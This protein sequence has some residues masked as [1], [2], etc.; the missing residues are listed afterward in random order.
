MPKSFDADAEVLHDAMQGVGTDEKAIIGVLSQRTRAEMHDVDI[1]YRSKYGRMLVDKIKSEFSG[2]LERI[3]TNVVQPPALTDAIYLHDSMA[4]AGTDETV[5][6]EILATRTGEEMEKIKLAYVET[7]RNGLEQAVK[8]DTSGSIEDLLVALVNGPR[9]REGHQVDHNRAKEDARRLESQPTENNFIFIL[10][11]SSHEHILAVGEEL[12]KEFG[13]SLIDFI[14]K[15]CSG[16]FEDLLVIL[17]TP[18]AEFFA[19]RL[20]KAMKGMGTDDETLIR[21]IT[22]RYGVDLPAI[23]AAF[24]AKHGKSLYNEVKSETSGDYEKMLLGL[25]D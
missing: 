5:L 15:K 4:G 16:K 10:G 18:R 11:N 7:Y 25:L 9:G 20:Y 21:V 19:E 1:A 14:K 17:A 8:G 6:F 2:K 24:Q 22:T 13:K 12:K 3:L 23:K